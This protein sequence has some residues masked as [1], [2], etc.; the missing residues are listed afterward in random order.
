MLLICVINL[1]SLALVNISD[2]P[3]VEPSSTIIISNKSFLKRELRS[4]KVPS[5]ASASLKTGITIEYKMTSP[6][7]CY[8]LVMQHKK[9][10]TINIYLLFFVWKG[11]IDL[12]LLKRILIIGIILSFSF[13]SKRSI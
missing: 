1:I 3:S 12:M 6:F 10:A 2:V 13:L 9:Y 7:I 5:I 8:N 4:F 11:I